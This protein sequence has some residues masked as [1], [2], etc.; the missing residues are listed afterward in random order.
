MATNDNLIADTK[1]WWI[2]NH[3]M[4]PN[5]SKLALDTYSVPAMSA[6]VERVFSRYFSLITVIPNDC[7]QFHAH[8]TKMTITDCRNPLKED[9]IGLIS[10]E[11]AKKISVGLEAL[12]NQALNMEIKRACSQGDIDQDL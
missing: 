10:F 7:L 12:E 6:E 5:L 8:S 4:Y 9:V 2:A 1:A 3:S 11:D